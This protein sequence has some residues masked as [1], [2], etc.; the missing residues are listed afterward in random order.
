MGAGGHRQCRNLYGVR[1]EG[2]RLALWHSCRG[3]GDRL[4]AWAGHLCM[5]SPPRGVRRWLR[6]PDQ[7]QRLKDA[8]PSCG[9]FFV[10][11]IC[12]RS[13]AGPRPPGRPE[14]ASSNSDD[15]PLERW[16]GWVI[17]SSQRVQSSGRRAGGQRRGATIED[18]VDTHMLTGSNL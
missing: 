17:Q 13:K 12:E 8:S 4:R 18:H 9:A 11:S 14:A 5:A 1:A 10:F 15:P 6:G 2:G 7:T 3:R 16:Q